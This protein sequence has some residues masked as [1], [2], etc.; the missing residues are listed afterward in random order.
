MFEL[1]INSKKSGDNIVL[2]S[3]GDLSQF[4]TVRNV[5]ILDNGYKFNKGSWSQVYWRNFRLSNVIDSI[6]IVVR[7]TE[8]IPDA[9]Y[10]YVYHPWVGG[11]L[12]ITYNVT[13]VFEVIL[14]VNGDYFYFSNGNLIKSGN[15]ITEGVHQAYQEKGGIYLL[16]AEQST[17]IVK[18]ILILQNPHRQSDSLYNPEINDVEIN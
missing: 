7:I 8:N 17:M 2:I 12:Y 14:N 11:G 13:G 1:L 5:T 10:T 4:Q 16:A 15:F 18:D 9:G 3:R 6:R